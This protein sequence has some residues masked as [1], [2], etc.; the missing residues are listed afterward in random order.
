MAELNYEKL[1]AD[2]KLEIGVAIGY[3]FDAEFASM[4]NFLKSA[5]FTLNA[6]H[7]KFYDVYSRKKMYQ[8]KKT[9][10]DP[11]PASVEILIEISIMYSG[12]DNPKST[13]SDF[14]ANKEVVLYSGHARAGHGP[15][16]DGDDV[17]TQ[18]FVIGDNSFYHRSGVLPRT[19]FYNHA[20]I[21]KNQ[22]NDLEAMSR[23]K[24]FRNGS[25]R[26][27]FFNACS[28][29]N[30]LD[31]VRGVWKKNMFQGSLVRDEKGNRISSDNL[32]FFGTRHSI[33]TDA[34][35]LLKELIDFHTMDQIVNK[36]S[37]SEKNIRKGNTDPK[38][39]VFQNDTFFSN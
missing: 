29:K 35:P 18:N 11:N 15:D 13:F 14:L 21:P 34:L 36:M 12:K 7:T 26:A 24:K 9:K 28:S 25:Y 10:A 22:Q 19:P 39:R 17:T 3:E 4:V 20:Q 1:L 37:E 8:K 5:G 6:R 38:E 32:L 33:Y 30:Y 23:D 16:F 27:W 2:K 31:E